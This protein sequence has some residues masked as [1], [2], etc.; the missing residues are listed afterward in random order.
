MKGF[1]APLFLLVFLLAGVQQANAVQTFKEWKSSQVLDAQGKIVRLRQQLEI[2]KAKA[3]VRRDLAIKDPNLVLVKSQSTEAAS[4]V[5]AQTEKLEKMLREELYDLEVAQ[6]LTVSDYFAGYLTKLQDKKSAFN[7][8][9]GK[10]SPEEVA[11]LMTAYANSAFGSHTPT[12][13][14]SAVNV[15]KDPLK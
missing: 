6:D 5:D 8:V 10:L 1:F 14:A 9:A 13:P 12:A 11:E 15:T 7:E 3:P 2:R 4:G